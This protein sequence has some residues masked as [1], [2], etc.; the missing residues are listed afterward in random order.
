MAG[1]DPANPQLEIRKKDV[2]VRHQD[3]Y[4]RL[5]RTMA[6]HAEAEA[7]PGKWWAFPG[8]WRWRILLFGLTIPRYQSAGTGGRHPLP[9][10]ETHLTWR[11]PDV[12]QTIAFERR[13]P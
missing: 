11:K 7:V 1:L 8:P 4:V 2:D 13:R 9:A 10:Q 12:P 3:V 5:R 6:G